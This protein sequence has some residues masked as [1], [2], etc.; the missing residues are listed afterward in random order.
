VGFF[1]PVIN[2][3]SGSIPCRDQGGPIIPGTVRFSF[4]IKA[5]IWLAFLSL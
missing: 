4:T 3:F 2:V 1:V 5:A